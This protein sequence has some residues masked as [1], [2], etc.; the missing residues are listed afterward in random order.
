MLRKANKFV[1]VSPP[2]KASRESRLSKDSRPL[3][4]IAGENDK[5]AP[6]D[7]LRQIFSDYKTPPPMKVIEGANFSFMGHEPEVGKVIV[8]FLQDCETEPA[9]R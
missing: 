4:I 7:S 1:L 8:N 9:K 3:L 2:P 5:L 6:P